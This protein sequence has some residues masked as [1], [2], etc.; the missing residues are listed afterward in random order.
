MSSLETAMFFSVGWSTTND[1]T[2][3]C[4]GILLKS[5]LRDVGM[6]EVERENDVTRANDNHRGRNE[7]LRCPIV[8]VPAERLTIYR[9]AIS[10][11][12][13]TSNVARRLEPWMSR[14]RTRKFH[15]T[16]DLSPWVIQRDKEI[17]LFKNNS[18]GWL[19]SREE[20]KVFI[21][22]RGWGPNS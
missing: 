20:S 22:K 21:P 5:E 19:F 14:P 17:L 18:S 12:F 4:R 10:S 7:A 3:R 8:L 16:R 9:F 15:Y 6:A 13:S 2:P 1:K 11:A